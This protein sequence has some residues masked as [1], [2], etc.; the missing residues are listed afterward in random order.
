M[1]SL[2]KIEGE[3]NNS[4]KRKIYISKSNSVFPPELTATMGNSGNEYVGE[5]I[6][7]QP[8]KVDGDSWLIKYLKT[9]KKPL[10]LIFIDAALHGTNNS[11]FQDALLYKSVSDKSPYKWTRLIRSD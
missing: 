8:E 6:P 9:G 1:I 2:E 4:P 11:L 5:A 7:A 10:D 3:P